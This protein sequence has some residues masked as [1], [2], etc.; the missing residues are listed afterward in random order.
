MKFIILSVTILLSGCGAYTYIPTPAY[1]PVSRE[2]GNVTANVS[3][4]FYQIGY[5]ISNHFSIFTAG[6]GNKHKHSLL[7]EETDLNYG[8]HNKRDEFHQFDFGGSYYAPLGKYLSYEIVSGIGAGKADYKNYWHYE[9]DTDSPLDYD[10][11]FTSHKAALFV[12][13]CISLHDEE[14]VDL[15]IFGRFNYTKYYDI[16]SNLDLGSGYY[17]DITKYDTYFYNKKS[18]DLLFFEPGFQLEL[19]YKKYGGM[20]LCSEVISLE[21][22]VQGYPK[23]Y[24]YLGFHFTYN[25]LED[26]K[27]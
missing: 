15:T 12:Q 3:F 11:S 23:F 17:S 20:V 9:K 18:A 26:L 5:A 21:P 25:L 13:P 19:R 8:R 10:F 16:N 1:V 6:N 24:M 4:K 22:G 7:V 2:K 27:K 14:T